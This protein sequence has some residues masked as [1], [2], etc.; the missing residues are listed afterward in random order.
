M[1]E[2]GLHVPADEIP[3]LAPTPL[4]IAREKRVRAVEKERQNRLWHQEVIIWLTEQRM[5]LLGSCHGCVTI[6]M[7]KM[8]KLGEVS[9]YQDLKKT[10]EK[11]PLIEIGPHGRR[12]GAY[13]PFDRQ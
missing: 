9:V 10:P 6:T 7:R 8:L 12:R 2:E 1:E 5:E 4:E 3:L 13:L 11:L